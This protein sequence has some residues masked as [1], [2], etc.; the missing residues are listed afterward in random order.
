MT[1]SLFSNRLV[2]AAECFHMMNILSIY[3]LCN[4]YNFPYLVL[5]ESSVYLVKL[6]SCIILALI[7]FIMERSQDSSEIT[8]SFLLHY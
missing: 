6:N 4:L 1:C 3:T 8:F 7:V 2:D 5:R